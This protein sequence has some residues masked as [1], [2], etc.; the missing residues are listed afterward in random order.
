MKPLCSQQF[1]NRNNFTQTAMQITK[2]IYTATCLIKMN[3]L[4]NFKAQ[5]NSKSRYELRKRCGK[6]QCLLLKDKDAFNSG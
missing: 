6:P 3:K 2:H 5:D 4:V 1:M